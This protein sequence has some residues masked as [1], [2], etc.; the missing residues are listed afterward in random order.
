MQYNKT[1]DILGVNVAV[2]DMDKIC[3]FLTD[4]LEKLRG[5]YICV[6]N[7]HTIV[8]A[9]ENDSYKKIQNEAAVVLPDGKPL[10]VLERKQ[11]KYRDRI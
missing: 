11:K 7:V 1:Y 9:H 2:T 4:N 3:S 6:S 10:S 5:D 8:M